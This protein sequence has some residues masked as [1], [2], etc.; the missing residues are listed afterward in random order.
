MRV[1]KL[2]IDGVPYYVKRIKDA[3]LRKEVPEGKTK[4]P[5]HVCVICW[6]LLSLTR[7]KAAAGRFLTTI[8]LSHLRTAHPE[9]D[10][11]AISQTGLDTK[12]RRRSAGMLFAGGDE[13]AAAA[14]AAGLAAGLATSF[15][16]SASAIALSK[17]ARFYVYSRAPISK[18]T[19]DDDDFR[20]M[21]QGYFD[22]GGGVGKAPFLTAKGLKAYVL[23]EYAIFKYLAVSSGIRVRIRVRLVEGCVIRVR[24]RVRLGRGWSFVFVFVFV[25]WGR[26][27]S[28]SC[29]H[30]DSALSEFRPLR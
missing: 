10:L 22:A 15:Y 16:L 2:K 9:L 6:E 4:P 23:E 28:G 20:D 30:S 21:C 18:Q 3:K 17:S 27:Y 14:S 1:T 26:G 24:V 25:L 5:T 8:A 19:F 7:D 13:P 11:S 29:S 12:A